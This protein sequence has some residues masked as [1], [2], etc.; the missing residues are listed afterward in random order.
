M[1]PIDLEIARVERAAMDF[2]MQMVVVRFS[3]E[4]EEIPIL[5]YMIP[6][7]GQ[8]I[9]RDNVRKYQVTDAVH[10]MVEF[11]G[12]QCFRIRVFA[13]LLPPSNERENKST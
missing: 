1:R 3:D 2:G 13:K 10:Q 9:I 11:E 7:V 8:T 12:F 5:A 6:H 4:R